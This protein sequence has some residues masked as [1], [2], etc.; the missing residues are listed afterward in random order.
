MEDVAIGF[1]NGGADD[2]VR[3][4]LVMVRVQLAD[5]P[6]SMLTRRRA[7]F[8]ILL[9]PQR[10]SLPAATRLRP[11]DL[12]RRTA[13]GFQHTRRT[14]ATGEK[15]RRIEDRSLRPEIRDLHS[16]TA[17]EQQERAERGP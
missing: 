7:E 10:L 5:G 4:R 3:G 2:V 13:A 15:L 17:R 9:Q 6:R 14:R 1:A 12:F 11:D 16:C 8:E